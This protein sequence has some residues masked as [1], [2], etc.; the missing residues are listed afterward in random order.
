MAARP[1][2]SRGPGRESARSL[3]AGWLA[4]CAEPGSRPSVRAA[5]PRAKCR[6]SRRPRPRPGAASC[7]PRDGDAWPAVTGPPSSRRGC[8]KASSSVCGRFRRRDH[9]ARGVQHHRLRGISVP[10]QQHRQ[11]EERPVLRVVQIGQSRADVLLRGW[12]ALPPRSAPARRRHW[13]AG[14]Q[15][16]LTA[17]VTGAAHRDSRLGHVPD[18]AGSRQLTQIQTLLGRNKKLSS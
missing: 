15:A 10:R 4:A 2:R 3:P 13:A 14:C 7:R 11:P 9:A 1:A 6:C 17:R 16:G 12:S 8:G 5:V 18:S